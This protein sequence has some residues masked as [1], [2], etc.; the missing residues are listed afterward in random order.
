[1]S[2]L[3]SVVDL[4][5]Q[6]RAQI[7]CPQLVLDYVLRALLSAEDGVQH[8]NSVA[9]LTELQVDLVVEQFRVRATD[10]LVVVYDQKAVD[11]YAKLNIE[12]S[13]REG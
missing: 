13:K 3:W 10:H 7:Q 11:V 1:M 12:S 8:V 5:H 2:S 6:Q 9:H 4:R